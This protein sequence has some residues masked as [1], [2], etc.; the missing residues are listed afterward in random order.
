[1]EEDSGSMALLTVLAAAGEEAP[2]CCI[3]PALTPEATRPWPR[4]SLVFSSVQLECLA[5][6]EAP[7]MEPEQP[8]HGSSGGGLHWSA[9][10]RIAHSEF[11]E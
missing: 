9:L 6:W 2:G 5:L 1:M 4:H 11:I 8:R 3:L 10:P 7:K